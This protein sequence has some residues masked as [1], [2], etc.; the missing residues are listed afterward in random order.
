M[1]CIFQTM[2]MAKY[3]IAYI[4]IVSNGHSAGIRFFLQNAAINYTVTT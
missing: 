4:Y 3:L 1:G 2:D